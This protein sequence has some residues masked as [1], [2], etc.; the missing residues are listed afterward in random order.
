MWIEDRFT[1][2]ALLLDLGAY[3][4]VFVVNKHNYPT[5]PVIL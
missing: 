3:F 4:S 1:Y 5:N 2:G